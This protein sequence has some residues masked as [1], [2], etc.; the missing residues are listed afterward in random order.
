MNPLDKN[1]ILKVVKKHDKI[2]IVDIDHVSGGLTNEIHSLIADKFKNK[3]IK[4]IGN[5]FLPAPV[6]VELEKQFYPSAQIIYDECCKLLNIKKI[7]KNINDD[8]K[9][10]GPY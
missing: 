3:I 6:S 7:K 4:K 5:K 9:F 1:Q 2:M 8:Q 10:F